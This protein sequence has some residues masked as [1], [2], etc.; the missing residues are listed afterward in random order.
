MTRW[1]CS[2]WWQRSGLACASSDGSYAWLAACAAALA[3]SN[4]A[5]YATLAW[6]PVVIGVAILHAWDM[7]APSAQARISLAAEQPPDLGLLACGGPLVLAGRQ[8]HH[9]GPHHPLRPGFAVRRAMA[10]FALTAVLVVPAV[11]GVAMSI[12]RR[13]PLHFTA[14]CLLVLAALIAP[15][16]QA[17]IQELA[18]LDKNMGF[19]LPF[20][21]TA[22]GY[23]CSAAID[24]TGNRHPRGKIAVSMLAAALV[25]VALVA[26][27]KQSVQ[28][29]G[30]SRAATAQVVSAI[31]HGYRSGTYILSDGAARTEQYYLPAIPA[32]A[33][34]AIFNPAAAQRAQ[35]RGR[36]CAG[37]VSLVLLRQDRGSYDNP[38]DD[39]VRQLLQSTKRYKLAAAAAN[40]NYTTQVWQLTA[41]PGPGSCP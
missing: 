14:C 35:F 39:Q 22:A 17:R 28:F 1:P 34:T 16:D 10:G 31:R 25:I 6:D 12:A 38:Y 24:W 8:G 4:A 18:S 13:I 3:I 23:G 41:P 30:P 15:I 32:T 36:I 37:Q 19:G 2:S 40:G 21:A 5:K 7:G 9:R 27:R 29:R 26:G 11:L 20:A 33:W